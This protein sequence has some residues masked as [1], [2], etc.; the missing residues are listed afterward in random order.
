MLLGTRLRLKKR[1]F[2]IVRLTLCEVVQ[3]ELPQT[4]TEAR[5]CVH[6]SWA[7]RPFLLLL[8][9]A[10]VVLCRRHRLET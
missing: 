2:R 1:Y 3:C 8:L 6:R 5:A 4:V 7:A 10:A 9:I